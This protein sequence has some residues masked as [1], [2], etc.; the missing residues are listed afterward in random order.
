MNS[1]LNK[2]TGF[3]QAVM[4]WFILS[5]SWFFGVAL[6]L[7]VLGVAPSTA[8]LIGATDERFVEGSA[9]SVWRLF[10]RRYRKWFNSSSRA[11]LPAIVI[12][13]FLAGDYVLM[14]RLFE[15]E[16]RITF[17][18]ILGLLIVSIGLAT[19]Y[20]L[21]SFVGG[22]MLGLIE[23]LGVVLKKPLH[24]LVFITV[25]FA[26]LRLGGEIYGFILLLGPGIWAWLI[27]ILGE[28][29]DRRSR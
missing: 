27:V 13:G 12:L 10:W 17:T 6:G 1:V 4:D 14:R 24:N 25:T 18:V 5:V 21:R 3:S 2:L 9:T 29:I 7:V 8:A 23:S 20:Q 11:I 19:I 16:V 26:V 15:G 22:E 28:R